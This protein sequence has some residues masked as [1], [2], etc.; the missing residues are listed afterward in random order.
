MLV[1]FDPEACTYGYL[2]WEVILNKERVAIRRLSFVR[3]ALALLVSFIYQGPKS[4][5]VRRT[6]LASGTEMQGDVGMDASGTIFM[7]K[8]ECYS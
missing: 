6:I 4:K 5:V 2:S 8:A 1:P 3:L 7:Y